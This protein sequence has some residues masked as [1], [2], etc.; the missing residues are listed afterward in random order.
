MSAFSQKRTLGP[1][2][3]DPIS[4]VF[5]SSVRAAGTVGHAAVEG[6]ADQADGLAVAST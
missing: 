6:D 3:T 1:G 4:F 5:L 2:L